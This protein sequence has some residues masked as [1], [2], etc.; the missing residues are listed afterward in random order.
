[1]SSD[2][3]VLV[4]VFVTA[5]MILLSGFAGD[6]DRWNGYSPDVED[7]PLLLIAYNCAS[8]FS[9]EWISLRGIAA[10]VSM[11]RSS[12]EGV[13]VWLPRVRGVAAGFGT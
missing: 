9:T 12:C 10:S 6:L 7:E 4:L 2:Q 13:R 11:P 5:L 1:M 8:F 3:S